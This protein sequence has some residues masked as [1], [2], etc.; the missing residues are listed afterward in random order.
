[1]GAYN[2]E[3]EEFMKKKLFKKISKAAQKSKDFSAFIDGVIFA[4]EIIGDVLTEIINKKEI[5]KFNDA[6]EKKEKAPA[7]KKEV[8][9]K[10]K[11]KA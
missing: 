3:T 10:S 8:A 5:S 4:Q 7:K 2:Q 9:S 11:K 1:M 6:P